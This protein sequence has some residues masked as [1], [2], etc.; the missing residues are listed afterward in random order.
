M[1]LSEELPIFGASYSLLEKLIDV[2]KDLPR[3]LRYTVGSRMIDAN[4]DLLMRVYRTNM[5]DDRQKEMNEMLISQ[6]MIQ[7]LLRVVY[8]EKSI[9]SGRYAE[10]L[11]LLD[12][13]GRQITAWKKSD[14][15]GG[16]D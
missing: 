4:L 16:S 6:R 9:S 8:R 14:G 12:T 13:I 7:M 15:T 3:M 10:L 2:E 5:S 1:A 11:K